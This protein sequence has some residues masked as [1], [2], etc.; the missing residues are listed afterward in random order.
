MKISTQWKFVGGLMVLIGVN[1]V[2]TGSAGLT[3]YGRAEGVAARVVGVLMM[4]TGL[5]LVFPRKPK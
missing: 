2:F 1:A 3:L 5:F 4:I